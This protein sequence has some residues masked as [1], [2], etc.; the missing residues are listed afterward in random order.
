MENNS[1]LIAY[2]AW[3]DRIKNASNEEFFPLLRE[4]FNLLINENQNKIS[5]LENEIKYIDERLNNLEVRALEE[6]ENLLREIEEEAENE[7]IRTLP[8]IE[9]YKATKKAKE[10]DPTM[11]ISPPLPE[12]LNDA[13]RHTLE[14]LRNSGKFK[15]FRKDLFNCHIEVEPRIGKESRFYY[16]NY[17]KFYEIYP[18]FKEYKEY[19]SKISREYGEEMRPYAAYKIIERWSD[20]NHRRDVGLA[21]LGEK[22]RSRILTALNVLVLYLSSKKVLMENVKR[23]FPKDLEWEEIT[24]RFLDGNDVI[25]YFRDK[26]FHT[27]YEEMGFANRKTDLPIKAWE[28]LR[29]LSQTNGEINYRTSQASNMGKKNKQIL[30]NLLIEYFGIKE[31]PFL[32]NRKEKTYSLRIKLIPERSENPQVEKDD[33]GIEDYLKETS[34]SIPT[35]S[36]FK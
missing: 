26:S 29:G 17:S 36:D 27:D 5:I 3:I 34:P 2:T 13:I 16:I 4:F 1:K 35:Y 9:D 15:D 6:L 28:F 24:I 22:I 14:N 8:E 19:S 23:E 18:A 12:L 20:E 32:C 31:D 7:G 25:I 30:K 10:E 21:D 11:L 33:L